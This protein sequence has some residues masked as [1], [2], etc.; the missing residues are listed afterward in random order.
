MDAQTQRRLFLMG[1][2]PME[3]ALGFLSTKTQ[4]RMEMARAADLWR[5]ANDLVRQNWQADSGACERVEVTDLPPELLE[6]ATALESSE[7]FGK[8]FAVVPARIKMVELAPLAIFQKTVN[9]TYTGQLEAQLSRDM[10]PAQLFDA[11]LALRDPPGVACAWPAL[12]AIQL[13]SCSS[14]LRFLEAI[15]LKDDLIA[16]LSVGGRAAAVVALVMGFGPNLITAIRVGNRLVLSNGSHRAYALLKLGYT[17]VPC[18]VQEVTRQEELP[19]VLGNVPQPL[20][21][22]LLSNPRPPMLR[23]LL[24]ETLT[25]II[26][27]PVEKRVV[28]VH[29]QVQNMDSPS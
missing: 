27:T 16:Q 29:W 24:N 2:P 26:S 18:V 1:F 28:T 19:I 23:D 6:K 13:S 25:C 4:P 3:E 8:S 15:P 17:K 11:C 22:Q 12:D 9:L 7:L 5:R 14:D 10:T 21:Q 20:L